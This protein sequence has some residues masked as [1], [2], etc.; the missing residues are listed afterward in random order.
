MTKNILLA[1][2]LT[3][4]T[5]DSDA[6]SFIGRQNPSIHNRSLTPELLWAMG[7]IGSSDVAPDA[8][9]ITYNV[10][11]YSVKENKS[12]TVIYTINTNGTGEKMLTEAKTS[13]VSPKYISGGKRIAYLGVSDDGNMQLFA[14]NTD[15]TNRKQLSNEAEGVDD[16]LFSPDEKKVILIKTVKYGQRT[17]DIYPDLNKASGRII[18]ELMYRHWDEWVENI[19]QPFVADFDGQSVTNATSI[20]A[21]EKFECP[22]KPFGGIEQLAWSPDS[23]QIAYT[24]RKLEGKEYSCSTDADIYIYN[25]STNETTNICKGKDYVRP[26]ITHTES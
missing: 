20:L 6:Q 24:C 22:M 8:K 19:P 9:S 15:G 11:Y 17:N 18:N 1:T 2:L 16:F 25:M 10:S 14:M 21:D 5:I 23:K 7:R 12:H 3:M 4:A 13:E 26:A